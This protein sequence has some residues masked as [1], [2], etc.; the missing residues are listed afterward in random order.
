MKKIYNPIEIEKKIQKKWEIKNSFKVFEDFKKKKYYCL[1][2]LPYPS[3]KL[4]LGHVRN[5]TISDVISR[6]YRMLGRNVLQPIGWDSFGLPAEEAAIKNK[7]NP[8]KWTSK[9]IKYMKKQLKYLGFSYDW[10]REI[11]TCNPKYYKWEQWFFIKLYK[12]KIAYKKTSLVKWCEKDQTV[13]ANE[14]VIKGKCWRCNKK[15][16][17]KKMS[18]WYLKIKKYAEELY[19]GIK[20]LKHWPK[21]VKKMQKN[22]IGRSKGIE[23]KLNIKNNNKIIKAYT[24]KPYSL[25]DSKYIA[26]SPDHKFAKK[27]AKSNNKI[28]KFIEKQE[29]KLTST[30]NFKKI[31]NYG[32]NTKIFAINPINNN[33]LP[34]WIANFVF[35]KYGTEII[36]SSPKYSL[37]ENKFYLKNKIN[38]KKYLKKEIEKNKK[39]IKKKIR[40]LKK[41]NKIIKIKKIG[42]KKIKYKLQDW[43]IS[44]QRYWGTPIPMATTKSGLILT[45]PK[46]KLPVLLPEISNYKEKK[47]I[48]K[49][50]AKIE[51]NG[52]KAKREIDTFDTFIESSWY[53]VRYTCTHFK[54]KMINHLASKYWLPVDQYV[55]G[56]EHATMHLIYFRFYHKLLRDF[57]LVKTNEPVKKLLCQGM[58]LSD[59]FYYLNK[60]NVRVWINK[61][62]I[63]YKKN[64]KGE[65]SSIKKINGKK[66]IHAGMIKMSKSKNNGIEPKKFIKKYGADTIRLFIMFSAPIESDLQWKESNIKGIHKF[67]NKIW[68]MCY[69]N[70]FNKKKIKKIKVSKLNS[71]QKKIYSNLNKT[72]LYVSKEIKE[73]RSFNTSI[74]RI[75]KFFKYIKKKKIDKNK[76]FFLNRK[77]LI[78]ILKL[79]NPFTPHFS[80]KILSKFKKI[81]FF[82]INKWPNV[83]KKLIIKKKIKIIIQIDGK[84]YCIILIKKNLSKNKILKLAMK[85]KKIIKN[86]KNKKIKKMFFIPKKILN[87]ITKK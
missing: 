53:Y 15:I 39:N 54:K 36:I 7:K 49:K 35:I 23:I 85:N 74:S 18:Q 21:K 68:N 11:S 5:Y 37:K 16:K 87:F 20:N 76:Y 26:I 78:T 61:N 60:D 30:E 28:K 29:K 52:I 1:P 57:N 34:I 32:I 46:K 40:K 86:L 75:M 41:I 67:L 31:K 22:W 69:K 50:W 10:S 8:K 51:I 83:N 70:I 38:K 2:M 56:I 9:N 48:L 79:L 25:F 71:K 44:R 66:I 62:K 73:K 82:K 19:Q 6:Y 24:T 77:C 17:L 43:N 55:G 81:S 27:I 47:K 45:I 59:A 84:M 3:G 72:I 80:Y 33:K 42:K 13:L 14:Q 58:V 63:K 4:H 64:K 65:I 12:K